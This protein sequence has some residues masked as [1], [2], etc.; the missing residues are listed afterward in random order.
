MLRKMVF[1]DSDNCG[2]TDFLAIFDSFRIIEANKEGIIP[3][4]QN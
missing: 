3:V 1:W 2:V 4:F